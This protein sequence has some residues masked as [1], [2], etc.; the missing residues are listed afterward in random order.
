MLVVRRLPHTGEPVAGVLRTQSWFALGNGVIVIQG[1]A[2]LVILGF[3]GSFTLAGVYGP[4]LRTAYSA[5]LIAEALSWG[6]YGRVGTALEGGRSDREAT[7]S[8][9][10]AA[11]ALGSAIALVFV[12]V[13]QPLLE[14]LLDREVD[15]VTG[16]IALFGVLIV[17]RF[18]SFSLSTRI[19]RAGRQR[20]QIPVLAI[21]AVVLA[22][23]AL[24]GAL[25][26]S[27]IALAAVRLAS[28]LVL[29]V[30]YARLMREEAGVPA[31]P[32][33]ASSTPSTR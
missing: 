24:V 21:A 14:F 29:L 5:L 9:I 10:I 33:A 19:V 31:R 11:T 6:L 30:G 13:A 12:L 1:Q 17:V 2:D 4:L 18:V 27:I 26:E 7:R 32:A 28:E 22:G 16:A 20:R 3:A 15:G 25:A 23:G 8:W